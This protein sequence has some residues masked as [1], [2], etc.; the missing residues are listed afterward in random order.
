MINLKM[1]RSCKNCQLSE[2]GECL[3]NFPVER[4]K[5]FPY[6]SYPTQKCHKVTSLKDYMTIIRSIEVYY[7]IGD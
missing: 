4:S 6:L 3:L 7:H 2:N 1:P 5:T